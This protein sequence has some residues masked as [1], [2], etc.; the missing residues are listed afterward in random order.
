MTTF[1]NVIL[2]L[3]KTKYFETMLSVLIFL[4]CF[5]LSYTLF[6]RR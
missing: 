3:L 2:F 1:L 6:I 4:G 5:K